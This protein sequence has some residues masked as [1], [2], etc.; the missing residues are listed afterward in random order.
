[1]GVC[2]AFDSIFYIKGLLKTAKITLQT[3]FSTQEV[4]E[5][6][7]FLNFK[8]KPTVNINITFNIHQMCERSFFRQNEHINF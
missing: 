5:R 6:G 7:W 3:Q 1:M 8:M 4:L 2:Q